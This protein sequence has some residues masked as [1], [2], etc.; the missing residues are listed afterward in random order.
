VDKTTSKNKNV[1]GSIGECSKTQVWI[2]VSI[3]VLVAISKKH[4]MLKQSLYEIVQVLGISIF[5]KVPV[6]RLFENEDL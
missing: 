4:C 2:A 1:L 5:E 3:Y 6:N